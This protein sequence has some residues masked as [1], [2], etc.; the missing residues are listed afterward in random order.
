MGNGP[1]AMILGLDGLRKLTAFEGRYL[2][3][4]YSK[5][6]ALDSYVFTK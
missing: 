2:S 3:G 4:V 6:S 5:K 1:V